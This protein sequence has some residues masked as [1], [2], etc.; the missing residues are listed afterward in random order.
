MSVGMSDRAGGGG[1]ERPIGLIEWQARRWWPGKQCRIAP[2]Q[3]WR[4]S[5]ARSAP[6]DNAAWKE[7]SGDG[8]RRAQ[9]DVFC[10][11]QVL[12]AA[13]PISVQSWQRKTY[14]TVVGSDSVDLRAAPPERNR[15]T[16]PNRSRD[17]NVR[18]IDWRRRLLQTDAAQS[19]NRMRARLAGSSMI[20]NR[21]RDDNLQQQ[22][23]AQVACSHV[24]RYWIRAGEWR[25]PHPLV[26][27]ECRRD[28][29]AL[30]EQCL[31]RRSG[32]GSVSDG[33]SVV[34]ALPDSP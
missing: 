31:H 8:G 11:I 19:Q 9:R 30:N 4:K 25:I 15:P 24:R 28:V 10:V 2:G 18:G 5:A 32:I 6:P 34:V 22:A 17:L 29:S 7:I 23:F 1:S 20:P 27:E 16:C 12:A 13:A 21:P 3:L 14:V 26:L 33:D